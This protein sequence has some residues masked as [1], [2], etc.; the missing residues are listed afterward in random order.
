[1]ETSGSHEPSPAVTSSDGVA[2]T[3][4]SGPADQAGGTHDAEEGKIDPIT[5][6]QDGIGTTNR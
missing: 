3:V 4:S 1:M 5:A 2:G 6:L